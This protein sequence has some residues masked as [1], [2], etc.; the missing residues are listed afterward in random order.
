MER[1]REGLGP[2]VG[3]GGRSRRPGGAGAGGRAGPALQPP[4]LWTRE[5]REPGCGLARRAA[6]FVTVLLRPQVP[7][8]GMHGRAGRG[9]HPS[10]PGTAVCSPLPEVDGHFTNNAS[11]L[12]SSWADLS[13]EPL[14]FARSRWWDWTLMPAAPDGS[15]ESEPHSLRHEK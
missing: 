2:C 5:A 8:V 12:W 14:G 7:I 13:P 10:G 9:L 1:V 4:A 6:A 11:S 15:G 3:C